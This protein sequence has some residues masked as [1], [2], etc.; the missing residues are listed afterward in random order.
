MWGKE[1][2]GGDKCAFRIG[3]NHG[4]LPGTALLVIWGSIQQQRWALKDDD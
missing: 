1:S 4:Y 2:A 3:F